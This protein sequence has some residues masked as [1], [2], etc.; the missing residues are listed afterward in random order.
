M[1]RASRLCRAPRP[2]RPGWGCPESAPMGLNLPLMSLDPKG[3]GRAEAP[4]SSSAQ[5]PCP[6]SILDTRPGSPSMPPQPSQQMDRAACRGH[7]IAKCQHWALGTGGDEREERGWKGTPSLAPFSPCPGACLLRLSFL[8]LCH[9]PQT[10]N[11]SPSKPA[12]GHINPEGL[13]LSALYLGGAEKEKTWEQAS[14]S[15]CY[16]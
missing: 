15:F 3:L 10:A 14:G 5:P 4:P 2:L 9:S 7:D 13:C 8:G 16:S 11:S 12:A 6:L 1:V